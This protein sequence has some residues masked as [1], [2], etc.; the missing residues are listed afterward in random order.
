MN[1]DQAHFFIQK[2]RYAYVINGRSVVL[3]LVD[4]AIKIEPDLPPPDML[5]CVLLSGQAILCF[6]DGDVWLEENDMFSIPMD[7]FLRPIS[8]TH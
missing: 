1:T 7:V 3:H 2:E 8:I 4:A 6:D 5:S